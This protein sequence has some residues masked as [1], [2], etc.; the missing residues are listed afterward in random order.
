MGLLLHQERYVACP[1]KV[2]R[3][4]KT[5]KSALDTRQIEQVIEMN[6]LSGAANNTGTNAFSMKRFGFVRAHT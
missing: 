6:I 1:F 3:K 4:L 5:K 2:R